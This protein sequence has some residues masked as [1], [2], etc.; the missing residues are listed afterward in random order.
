M[1]ASELV[2]LYAAGKRDFS[3]VNLTSA[4]LCGANFVG[5]NLNGADLVGVNLSNANLCG[6]SLIC[7]RMEH[8]NLSGANLYGASL[9]G[10]LYDV[11]LSGADLRYG[12]LAQANLL[13][14]DLNKAK[15]ENANLSGAELQ[16]ADLNDANLKYADLSFA[17]LEKANL[18]NANLEN[19]NLVKANLRNAYLICANLDCANLYGACLENV[20]SESADFSNANLIEVNFYGANLCKAKFRRSNLAYANMY[21]TTLRNADLSDAN[22]VGTVL[23]RNERG[24]VKFDRASLSRIE[25]FLNSKID[26]TTPLRSLQAD[27]ITRSKGGCLLHCEIEGQHSELTV[28]SGK[29]LNQLIDFCWEMAEKYKRNFA[30]RRVFENNLKG[31]LGEEVFKIRL[32]NFITEV[33]YEKRLGG[34]GKVDF[35]LTSNPSIG[36]QIKTCYGSI[37]RVRWEI[38]LEEVRENAALVCIVSQEEFDDRKGEYNLLLAGFLPTN[39][40]K[41]S[42][43]KA[44]IEINEL[45]YGGALRS[46]LEFLDSH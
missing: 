21:K 46:Y 4:N 12:D 34:D 1:D 41:V 30:V 5:I 31:K 9:G 15:L 3:G 27:F 10:D 16:C 22:L 42:N 8:S 44:S 17:N 11:D 13:N 14:A 6:A 43:G 29:N 23:Y 19:A 37:D 28:I 2:K 32:A 36:I 24:V 26:W 25:D 18:D 40:I 33:D 7:V 39:M 20:S 45:L 38:S 35:R